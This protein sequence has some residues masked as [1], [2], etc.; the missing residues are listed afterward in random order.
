MVAVWCVEVKV[1]ET[2][3]MVAV[4]MVVQWR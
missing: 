2:V 4:M 1:I 3:M